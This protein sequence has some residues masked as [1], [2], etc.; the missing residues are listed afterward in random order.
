MASNNDGDGM[1]DVD[2]A[3]RM[4][5]TV[6]NH[7]GA[8]GEVNHLTE[9]LASASIENENRR[10]LEI[11]KPFNNNNNNDDDRASSPKTIVFPPNTTPDEQLLILAG[12]QDYRLASQHP[13]SPYTFSPTNRLRSS[14]TYSPYQPVSPTATANTTTTTLTPA[15][16]YPTLRDYITTNYAW[17]LTTQRNDL[18]HTPLPTGPHELAELCA[19]MS[20][21]L[22]TQWLRFGMKPVLAPRR[23]ECWPY[24]VPEH[25]INVLIDEV[26]VELGE[27]EMEME[28]RG[29]TCRWDHVGD[30]ERL[31]WCWEEDEYGCAY[32]GEGEKYGGMGIEE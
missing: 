16:H 13:N 24:W 11:D 19:W 26:V 28:E 27:G 18:V 14:P 4:S 5:A 8:T 15:T 25:A 31:G 29:G 2:V 3:N 32:G 23:H 6:V 1:M 21:E 20:D 17:M 7:I 30:G 10:A 9:L 22:E 12:V